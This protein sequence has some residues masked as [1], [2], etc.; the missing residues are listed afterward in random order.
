MLTRPFYL[1]EK[2][3]GPNQTTRPETGPSSYRRNPILCLD[4][5]FHLTLTLGLT[6]F[7]PEWRGKEFHSRHPRALGYSHAVFLLVKEFR[8]IRHHPPPQPRW[9][10]ASQVLSSLNRRQPLFTLK[11]YALSHGFNQIVSKFVPAIGGLEK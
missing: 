2:E 10:T 4:S 6:S 3:I 8:G 11:K 7:F 1:S 5:V 9:G